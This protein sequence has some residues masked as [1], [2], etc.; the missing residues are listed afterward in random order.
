MTYKEASTD[1]RS[2][3][4]KGI[5]PLPDGSHQSGFLRM[6]LASARKQSETPSVGIIALEQAG[7]IS[8]AGAGG[9][10]QPHAVLLEQVED[11]DMPLVLFGIELRHCS[12]IEECGSVPL[13]LFSDG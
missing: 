13:D 6:H 10:Y 12:R 11:H 3:L 4:V 2:I 9:K 1:S 7:R 8:Y 5:E